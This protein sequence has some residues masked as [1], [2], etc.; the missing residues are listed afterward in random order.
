MSSDR[1]LELNLGVDEHDELDRKIDRALGRVGVVLRTFFVIALVA[2]AAFFI[3]IPQWETMGPF[4]MTGLA[5]VFQLFYVAFLM[6]FQFIV[7]FW[8]IGRPRIYWLMPGETG[9][10]FKDYKGNPEVLE[11]AR[12]VVTLLKG[13]KRFKQ[14]GGQPIRGLLLEG[15]PGTGKS[16][17]GQAIATESQLPFGYMSAPS[18]QGMFWGMDTLRVLSLYNKARKLA[19]KHGACILFIDEIDAIA[20]SRSGT[21]NA[22]GMGGMM[23]GGG[24]GGALNE[25]LNQMDPLPKDGMKDK[26]LRMFGIRKGKAEQPPVLTIAATNLVSVLDPALLRPGR[27]DRQLRVGAPSYDGRREIFDY[28]LS[29]VKHVDLPIDQ[30]VAETV[31]YSPAQ[32]KHVVN[33]SVVHAVWNGRD[34]IDYE[35]FRWALETYEWGLRMPVIGMTYSDKRRLAYHEAGHAVAAV[36]LLKRH[37]V[38]RATIEAR[39][40]IGAAALVAWKPLEEIHTKTKDELLAD[41]QISLASRASEQI[42]LGPGEEMSGAS[43]DLASATQTAEAMIK[44]FGMNG[45]LV[46]Y[47]GMLGGGGMFGGGGGGGREVDRL[48]DQQFKRVKMMLE[49]NRAAVVAVAEALIEKHALMGDEVYELVTRADARTNGHTNGHLKTEMPPLDAPAFEIGAGGRRIED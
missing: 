47:G 28:Y 37:R 19:R 48:L 44:L 10:G 2:F 45:S 21:G 40:D 18:I 16:Y 3:V 1:A 15:P 12:Q 41:I 9:V 39:H 14:M 17:L 8:F 38:A 11:S 49:E 4:I 24:G 22:G 6:I 23:F 27:F 42:F 35:D 26:F 20:K 5:L 31:N 46:S 25:L 43:G 7:L 13:V 29:K 33:E 36:K 32:I 34:A 30:M